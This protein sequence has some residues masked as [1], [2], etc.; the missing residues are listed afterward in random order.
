MVLITLSDW[1]LFPIREKEGLWKLVKQRFDGVEE[2][3]KNKV[4]Q[5]IGSLWR[6]WKS[7]LTS[8]LKKALKEGWS[9]DEINSKIKPEEVELVDWLAFRKTR[10]SSAFGE[11]SNKFKNL[12]SKHV[13]PH[14]MSRKGY[15]RLE[16][17]MRAKT[18]RTNI[19]RA[20]LWIEGHKNK[21]G[22]PNNAQI[23]EVVDKINESRMRS[24]A[25]ASQSINDNP[26][27]QVFGPEHQGRV[28][29]LGFGVTPSNVGVITQSTILV[30]KLLGD[31]Q[32]LEGKHEQLAELIHSQQIPPSSRQQQNDPPNLR[33]KKCKIFD[34]LSPNKLVGEGEVETDDPMHLVDGI[35]I[36]GSAYLVYVERVFEPNAFLWRNQNNWTTLDN[37]LGEIIPWPKEAVAVVFT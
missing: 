37:A 1:R 18:G 29:G 32:R 15:A 24:S 34:W 19:T 8:S 9:D 35:P 12:R 33:G 4:L 2:D 10:E 25:T 17:E 16:E 21:K 27:A 28:R 14:T 22:Q 31:F 20:D 30:L 36:G 6:S 23:A 11:M 13:Y 7:R 5:Q 26:I 3:L